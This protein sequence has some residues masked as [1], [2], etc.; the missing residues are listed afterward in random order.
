MRDKDAIVIFRISDGMPSGVV[1]YIDV[2]K[3]SILSFSEYEILILRFD[4][5]GRFHNVCYEKNEKVTEVNFPFLG[6]S[7][8]LNMDKHRLELHHDYIE[9]LILPHIMKYRRVVFHVQEMCLMELAVRLKQKVDCKIIFH[10]H[11]IPWKFIYQNDET[12]FNKIFQGYEKG[13]YSG[14]LENKLEIYSYTNADI[15]VPVT[16]MAKD[17]IVRVFGIESAKINVIYNGLFD[18]V[19]LRRYDCEEENASWLLFVGR[20]SKEK[21]IFDLLEALLHLPKN[22][23]YKLVIV[24]E[25]DSEFKEII[26]ARYSTIN[27]ELTGTIT[28][29]KLK[30]IYLKRPIGIIPSIHEQCS[31]TAIEMS[32]FGLPVIFSSVDGLKEIFTDGVSGL[33]I[34]LYFDELMGINRDFNEFANAILLMLSDKK[35]RYRYG[36]EARKNYCNNFTAKIMFDKINKIYASCLK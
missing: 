35:S 32:M 7:N 15:I 10:Q 11:V 29:D 19:P 27:A 3:K 24:G 8:P 20:V 16:E 28:F 5:N 22:V 31:Y 21:G 33:K 18:C 9:M 34:D 1:R 23:R 4:I 14:I 2:L 26:N 6:L 12:R 36:N 30:E 17:Y 25:Y 13:E